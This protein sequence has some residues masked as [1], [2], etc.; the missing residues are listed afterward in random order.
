MSLPLHASLVT[1]ASELVTETD[2]GIVVG[3]LVATDGLDSRAGIV[4]DEAVG[5]A[6]LDLRV[7]HAGI[8]I[9]V[10]GK[11]PIEHQRDCIQ[12]AGATR[13]DRR[14]AGTRGVGKTRG[15]WS[16]NLEAVLPLVVIRTGDVESR[17]D[18]VTCADPGRLQDPVGGEVG[19]VDGTGDKAAR[20]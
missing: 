19:V 1:P 20:E 16:A 2:A 5:E 17:R 18:R 9:D 13:G 15:P 6:V 3:R 4:D 8:H 7:H 14:A 10:P 12:C 11:T